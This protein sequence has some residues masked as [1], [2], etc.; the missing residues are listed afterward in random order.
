MQAKV[1][2]PPIFIEQEPQIPSLQDL[3]KVNEGSTSFFILRSASRTIGPQLK[4][5]NHINT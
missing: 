1:F 4:I 5:D 2:T 3:L